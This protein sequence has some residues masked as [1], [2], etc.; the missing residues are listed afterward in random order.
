[1][2][3]SHLRMEGKFY[4]YLQQEENSKYARM[5]FHLD[6][7]HKV[8]YDDSRC[9][10]IMILSD[11]SSYRNEKEIA[12]LAKEPFNADVKEIME[13]TKRLIQPIKTTI[14]DQSVICGLGNIYADETLYAS[15]IHPLTE[16]NTLKES[17]WKRLIANAI[18]ILNT[19]IKL[20]GST[21]KSYHPG[22]GVSG[23]FQ[24]RI[25]IYGKQDEECPICHKKFRF[26]TVGG[27][28]TTYCP[29]CQKKV[30]RNIKV[31]ITGKIASGKSLIL[32]MFKDDYH[33]E[34][35]SSDEVVNNLYNQPDI[36]KTL[37]KLLNLSFDNVVDKSI[38]REHLKNNP[39]DIKKINKFIHPLVGKEIEKFLKKNN[40]DIV[41]VEVPLLFESNLDRLF[42]YIIAVDI[43]S[44]KQETLLTH[45]N[46]ENTQF[47]KQIYQNCN[48]FEEYK[49]KADCLVINDK[50]KQELSKKVK[51]IFNRLKYLQD[52]SLL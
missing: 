1:M 50:D 13:K 38:L 35:L 39:N 40:K 47:L 19:A 5:V 8:C 23:E 7:N 45:R 9:F 12:K 2:V 31:A 48:D 10:G 3:I 32:K 16:T 44:D 34:T 6:N 14:L 4:E 37:G 41:V 42:D 26:T 25:K 52:Q 49:N 15:K 22:K 20:G 28:G 43:P 46:K 30:G 17:D 33:L 11:E 18:E 29:G 24:T 51:E 27:R 21:I 36:A